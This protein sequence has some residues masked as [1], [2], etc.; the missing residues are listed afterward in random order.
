MFR[1]IAMCLEAMQFRF[2]QMFGSR[3][4]V[5]SCRIVPC[6]FVSCHVMS[7]HVSCVVL[8][9]CFWGLSLGDKGGKLI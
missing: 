7:C 1:E 5:V 2:Q 9:S 8:V 4:R 3:C 6:R